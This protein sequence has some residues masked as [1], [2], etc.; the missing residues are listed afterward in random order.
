MHHG[1]EPLPDVPDVGGPTGRFPEGK[2]AEQD[3][4]EIKMI[5]GN[6]RDESGRTKVVIDFG[7]P[8]RWVGMNAQQA[9]D[10]AVMLQKHAR[11]ILR[12]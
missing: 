12:K 6:H 8:I 3:E 4:G 9:L 1:R 10:V 5:V 2:L 11:E 7:K